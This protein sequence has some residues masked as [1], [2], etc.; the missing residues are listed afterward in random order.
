[1][2]NFFKSFKKGLSKTKDNIVGKV[3]QAVGMAAK[4]DDNL[5]DEIEEILIQGDVGVS[6]SMK[7][8][9][10]LKKKVAHD[11]IKDAEQV[12]T[13]LKTE[14]SLIIQSDRDPGQLNEVGPTVWLIMGV[15]GTGKTTS[16]GKLAKYFSDSG[17]KTMVAACDT[18]RAAAVEQLSIWA[19]RS[20]VE[21]I[22]AK[23]GTDP[24]SVAFDA[25]SAAKA[26]GIDI[27]L[28]D[29]AGRLHT[30]SH[31]MEELGKIKRVISKVVPVENIK[32]K[33]VLD[34]TTGQ[35]ALSQVK[36]FTDAV[37]GCDGLI[38]TKLDGTAKGGVV[39]AI[40]E[41]MSVPI[42]F[43]GLGEQIDDLKPFDPQSYVDALFEK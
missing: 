39:I 29:T 1:M 30:K 25:V 38:V 37:E 42:D 15:N 13:E 7:I 27:L 14:I 23:D 11:N 31:L 22:K 20:G 9:E 19:E 28:V 5:L 32:P 35:N 18:F 43:I 26:R 34:G 21:F 3:R 10:N 33:L 36:I 6:A 41:E 24:A 40:A 2:R 8:I 17:K 12:I 16:V 4:V